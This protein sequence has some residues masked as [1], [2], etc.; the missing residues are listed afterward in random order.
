MNKYPRVKEV[1]NAYSKNGMGGVS[2]YLLN[3]DLIIDPNTW[4]GKMKRLLDSK[5][6]SS[7]EAEIASILF[8]FKL[9]EKN[10]ERK[11]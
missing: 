6:L 2:K 9:N 11:K 8:I 10:E 4:V 7:M 1:L 5:S 3:E